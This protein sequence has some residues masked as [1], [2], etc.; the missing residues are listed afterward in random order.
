M[1][2]ALFALF[3]LMAASFTGTASR[4]NVLFIALDD[5]NDW[6]GCLGGHPQAR[7]PNLDRLA[8][9][10]V[11]FDNAHCPAPACNPSRSAI[12]TG[13]SPHVS[14]LYANG[15]RMR[16]ALPD[17][18]L[19]PAYFARHGYWA[20]GSGKM[21]HYFIDA[22]SW[23]EYYPEKESENPFPAHMPWGSRPK[24]LPR[25][26]PWQYVETDWH[27]FDVTDDEFGGDAK[28]ADWV[29]KHLAQKRE[30]PFFLACGIYRPHE[31]WFVPKHYFDLFPLEQVL[32]PPG[33]REDDLDDLPESGKRA[34][35]N[36]YF[37]HIR[38]HGQWKQAV[39][40][41]LAAIAYA[42]AMLGRVLD[43]LDKSP[44][45]DN[46]IV[47]LWSDHGWHLGEKEH[48]QKFTV[49]RAATRVPLII[50]VP[51]GAPGLPRGTAAGTRCSA[52]VNL[53]SLFPTLTELCGLPGK[54]DN[55]GPSL[56]PLLR[57][58]TAPW[59]HVSLTWG[60]RPGTIGLSASGWRYLRY[61]DGG[62]ELYD[63][64][65]DPYEWHNLAGE[66]VH[67][68]TLAAL[69]ARAPG[70]FAPFAQPK[71]ASLPQL[72][73]NTGSA[74]ASRPDGNAFQVTFVNRRA[75]AVELS[76][77]DR[78]GTPRP[79]GLIAPDTTKGQQTRPGAVWQISVPGQAE[80]LGYFK[81]GDR[82]ARAVVPRN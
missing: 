20:G 40:A 21:L 46:T 35:P 59:P 61:P 53:L 80:P 29:S 75:Q 52:P 27:A 1:K 74:P 18:E 3:L 68:D 5:L 12:F 77:M 9:S 41:Y 2:K 15:Q 7:T 49:W 51:A 67:A 39:Q 26:G 38:R 63:I 71:L 47:A 78:Q 66:A 73:W 69:R 43:A 56:V 57:N 65:N 16:D 22:R 33:Y 31:P 58:A 55:S 6:V 48:W 54:D 32:L 50:R 79:F 4:P 25:G 24:S 44:H 23:D 36:R 30:T 13:L 60:H 28:V 64:R 11:L 70:R 82:A 37:A 17:A 19:L 34:G 10:G 81:V 45:R 76:W 14:G 72:S 8:S 62:E 42:D